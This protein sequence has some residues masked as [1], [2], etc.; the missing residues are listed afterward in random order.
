[1]I[2]TLT[3]GNSFRM[4]SKLDKLSQ[5]FIKEQGDLAVERIDGQEAEF[6]KIREALT[7]LPFLADKKLVIL[8]EGGANKKF[9]EEVE[10][11]IGEVPETTDVILVE[12]KLD[13]RLAYYKYLKKSTDF[14]EFNELDQNDLARWLADAAQAKGGSLNSNDARY[15][16]ERVGQNQQL[17]SNELEKLL[18]YDLKVTRQTIDLLTEPTPQS[19]IF[20]LLEAAFAGNQKRVLNLYAEQR[21]QKVEPQ[22]II[23]MLAWQLH[24][25]A[26]IKTAGGR[27]A[28]QIAQEAKLNPFVVRKSQGI[29]RDLSSG[30]VRKMVADL[31]KI[32]RA[33]KRTSIDTDEALQNYL[34]SLH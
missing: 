15:L 30:E 28:D 8:R 16:V 2:T 10:Q 3:G 22:Q 29:A 31:L 27:N 7:S 34:I 5:A 12:P 20:Q 21:A 1:M 11:I 14:Q 4:Q 33:S 24:V 23:A 25:L 17:L 9:A 26:L 32:D 19:T 18:L 13:K 6:E